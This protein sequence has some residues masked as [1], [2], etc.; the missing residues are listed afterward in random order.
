MYN[1]QNQVYIY[2]CVFHNKKQLKLNKKKNKKKQLKM[3]IDSIKFNICVMYIFISKVSNI[4]R[5]T[6]FVFCFA[7]SLIKSTHLLVCFFH[8]TISSLARLT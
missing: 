7:S 3:N 6:D 4:K 8:V 2:L 1:I 5:R